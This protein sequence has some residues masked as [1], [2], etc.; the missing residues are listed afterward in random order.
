MDG[1]KIVLVVVGGDDRYE[2]QIGGFF[3]LLLIVE[4]QSLGMIVIDVHFVRV[5]LRERGV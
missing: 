3:A 1:N 2:V 5:V 4:M